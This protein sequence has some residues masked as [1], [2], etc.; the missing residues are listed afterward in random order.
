MGMKNGLNRVVGVYKGVSE[1]E[2]KALFMRLGGVNK[3]LTSVENE[4]YTKLNGKKALRYT[5]IT[6]NGE[7][8]ILRNFSESS[9]KSGSIW[10]IDIQSKGKR[11]IE[12]KFQ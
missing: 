4:K 1:K 12:L 5:V 8:I 2:V 11:T 9:V 3:L 6:S 10:N 7:Q